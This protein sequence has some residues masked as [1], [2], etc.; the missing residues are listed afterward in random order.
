MR[1]HI[2]AFLMPAGLSLNECFG[3]FDGGI[4]KFGTRK[5]VCD[6]FDA[7]CF[8]EC[9]DVAVCGACGVFFIYAQMVVAQCGNLWKVGDAEHLAMC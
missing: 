1:L 9:F 4:G 6:F 3:I 7:L 5:H 8:V 2:L